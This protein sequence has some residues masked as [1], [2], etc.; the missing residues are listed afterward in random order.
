MMSRSRW[1]DAQT[2][3]S[4]SIRLFSLDYCLKGQKIISIVIVNQSLAFLF[5]PTSLHKGSEI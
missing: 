2:I 4:L 1:S 3:S 5:S